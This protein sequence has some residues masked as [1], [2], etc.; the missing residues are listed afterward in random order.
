MMNFLVALSFGFV[1]MQWV[2]ALL[3]VIFRQTIRKAAWPPTEMISILIPARNEEKNIGTLLERLHVMSNDRFEILV[4]DDHSTDQTASMV[5]A[6][7]QKDERIRLIHPVDL[8]QGW[9]GKNHAC[10]QLAQQ[11][12]GRF[13]LFV[14]AD[15]QLYG[16][17]IEDAVTYMKKKQLGLL[18]V[19]PKQIQV[20]LGEKLT[21]PLMNYILLTLLPLIFVNRSPF[22]SHAAANGQFMLFDAEWYKKMQPHEHVKSSAVEDILIARWYKEHHIKVACLTGETRIQCRMYTSYRD[23]FNGFSKNIFMFFGNMPT[24]AILFGL[25][26]TFGFVPLLVVHSWLLGWYLFMVVSI[27]ILYSLACKQSVSTAL[28][29]FPVH[30]FFLFQLIINAFIIKHKKNYTWKERQIYS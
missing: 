28:F 14:D 22:K 7:S 6:M 3:N 25:L 17:I 30:L 10:F 8:P 9:L 13:L 21:V 23:S 26:A 2:N 5:Q 20:T 4:Y 18:S 12:H 16:T 19:F 29:F 24:A 15:V 11:A 27:Q 1:I